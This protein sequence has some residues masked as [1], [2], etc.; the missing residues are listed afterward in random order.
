MSQVVLL[1]TGPLGLASAPRRSRQ[2]TACAE[3]LDSLLAQGTQVVLPEIADCEVRRELLRADKVKSI[4]RLDALARLLEYVP[5]TTALMRRAAQLWATARQQGKPTADE[6][7][8]D[9]DVILAAQ[10][11]S[12]STPDLVVATRNL[13]HTSQFVSAALW[14]DI[15][16]T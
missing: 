12:L 5:I 14:P 1:D 10:A 11:E 2:S 8:L 3:W 16:P 13:R 9:G 6:K 15:K 7:P 4:A